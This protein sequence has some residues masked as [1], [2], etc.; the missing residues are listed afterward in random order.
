M[1]EKKFFFFGQCMA[2]VFFRL[3]RKL[4]KIKLSWNSKNLFFLYMQLEKASLIKH[5]FSDPEKR[6][7]YLAEHLKLTL[8]MFLKY[9]H[10][11]FAWTSAFS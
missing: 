8:I 10:S 4:V 11:T 6:N 2:T 9:K 3:C 5:F 7:I 1:T